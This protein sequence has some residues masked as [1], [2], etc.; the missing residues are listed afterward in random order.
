M[1]AIIGHDIAKRDLEILAKRGDLAHGYIFFGAPR[2]GKYCFART[3]AY[4]LEKGEWPK[5]IE[6]WPLSDSLFLEPEEGS[7]GVDKIR[8]I[9]NFLSQ[10]PSLSTHRVVI[11]NDG[12]NLTDEAQNALLKVSEE[13]PASALIIVIVRDPEVLW[14]TLASRFQKMHFGPVV[15]SDIERWLVSCHGLK[16]KEAKNLSEK[17]RGAPG[18]ALAMKD[19]KEFQELQN[20]AEAFLNLKPTQTKDFLKELLDDELFQ[21]KDFLDALI[22]ISAQNRNRNIQFWHSMLELRRLVDSTGLNPRIQLFNLWILLS[23]N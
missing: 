8:E 23:K 17:A 13:P 2:I 21:F 20:T 18:L 22:L 12:E 19:N 14:P 11:V 6:S 3:F 15:K 16:E 7:L 4:F 5:N 10:K 1:Q 9:K